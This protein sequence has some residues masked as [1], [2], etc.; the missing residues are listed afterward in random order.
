MFDDRIQARVLID[1][2][3]ASLKNIGVLS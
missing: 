1:S 2:F 3:A